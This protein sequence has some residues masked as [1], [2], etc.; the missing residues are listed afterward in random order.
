MLSF[1][2]RNVP[3]PVHDHSLLVFCG[4]QAT[5]GHGALLVEPW[6]H[7]SYLVV[8]AVPDGVRSVVVGLANGE[9]RKVSVAD[10]SYHVV[11]PVEVAEVTFPGQ[12]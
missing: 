7:R 1:D 9:S 4:S 8:G 3:D 6:A 5:L 12:T 2:P 10:N 11:V